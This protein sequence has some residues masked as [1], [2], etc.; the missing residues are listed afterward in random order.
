MPTLSRQRAREEE[1]F[2]LRW[3]VL[4]SHSAKWAAA[5]WRP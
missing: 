2:Q 5:H 3:E 1:T 4:R